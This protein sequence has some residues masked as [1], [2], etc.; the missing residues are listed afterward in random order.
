MTPSFLENLLASGIFWIFDV[1]VIVLV[2]PA[3]IQHNANAKWRGMRSAI[4]SEFERFRQ[5]VTY[6][7]IGSGIKEAP[8]SADAL[9]IV[10]QT[11]SR[12]LANLRVRFGVLSQAM[13][14]E[15]APHVIVAFN[16]ADAIDHNLTSLLRSGTRIFAR[17][18]LDEIL[19]SAD[20]FDAAV[21][22]INRQ[23]KARKT[24]LGSMVGDFSEMKFYLEE[25]SALHIKG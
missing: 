5:Q 19:A 16:E 10:G 6:G 18:K 23:Y 20:R 24:I 14:P 1:L 4:A 9:N 12:S 11:S 7:V 17:E 22:E 25:Y 2:L 15:L 13:T 8:G 3:M 21:S